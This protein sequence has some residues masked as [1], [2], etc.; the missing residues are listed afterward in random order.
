METIMYAVL[1]ILGGLLLFAIISVGVKAPARMLQQNFVK[2]GNMTGKSYE[3][4]AAVVGPANA[5]SPKVGD[6][7]EVLTIKQ[8]IKPGYHISLVFDQDNRCIGKTHES[9]V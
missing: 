8:W 7:G 3:E 9:A 4:I 5:D 6:N 1:P 2:L